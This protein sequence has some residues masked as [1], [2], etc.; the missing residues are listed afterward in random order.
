M[1]RWGRVFLIRT[2]HASVPLISAAAK[3]SGWQS[4]VEKHR[5]D[6]TWPTCRCGRQRVQG[7][8]RAHFKLCEVGSAARGACWSGRIKVRLWWDMAPSLLFPCSSLCSSALSPFVSSLFSTPLPSCLFS[9]LVCSPCSLFL[10][11]SCRL[12]ER[13]RST[14]PVQKSWTCSLAGSK[15]FRW[16]EFFWSRYFPERQLAAPLQ[17]ARWKAGLCV[18]Q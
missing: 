1:R 3:S 6:Q 15:E 17:A 11:S 16:T 7:W 4:C 12:Q 18:E 14:T 5:S 10:S 13:R 2:R 9:S 8:V